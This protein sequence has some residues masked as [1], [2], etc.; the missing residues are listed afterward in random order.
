[1]IKMFRCA[2]TPIRLVSN[3]LILL[4]GFLHGTQHIGDWVV[5]RPGVSAL[6]SAEEDQV[7]VARPMG[8]IGQGALSSHVM[9]ATN[10]CFLISPS[11]VRLFETML[12]TYAALS[13]F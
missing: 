2:V 7:L 11:K 1:M 8:A 13:R 4:G 10:T 12:S 6:A 3:G 9:T 5:Y